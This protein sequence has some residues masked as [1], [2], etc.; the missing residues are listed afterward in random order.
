MAR[1]L[2][3]GSM[4]TAGAGGRGGLA[5]PGRAVARG[6]V[7]WLRGCGPSRRVGCGER[8]FVGSLRVFGAFVGL[9]ALLGRG[10]GARDG[11]GWWP[12]C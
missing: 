5:W 4:G 11:G 9:G 1:L 7:G 8:G 2:T 12:A 3:C 6:Y 10:P